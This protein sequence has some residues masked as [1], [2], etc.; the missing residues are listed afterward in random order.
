MA[1]NLETDADFKKRIKMFPRI[2]DHD[3]VV[4]IGDKTLMAHKEILMERM[5]YFR[6]MFTA[7]MQERKQNT[8]RLD[9]SIIDSLAFN[10]IL[11]FVYTFEANLTL[12]ILVPTLR[13]VDFFCFDEMKEYVKQ[14]IKANFDADNMGFLTEI[15]NEFNLQDLEEDRQL[16]ILSDPILTPQELYVFGGQD[17]PDTGEIAAVSKYDLQT[18]QWIDLPSISFLPDRFSYTSVNCHVYIHWWVG[19]ITEPVFRMFDT[20]TQQWTQLSPM[21]HPRICFSMVALDGYL[22]AAGGETT[23]EELNIVERYCI[24]N[25]QWTD[26]SPMISA[27]SELLEL[28]GFLYSI[29]GDFVERYNPRTDHWEYIAPKKTFQLFDCA[30]LDG[31]IYV[32]DDYTFGVYDP[33]ENKWTQLPASDYELMGRRLSVLNRR[34]FLTGGCNY[35][36]SISVTNTEYY[37]FEQRKWIPVKNMNIARTH[38]GVVVVPKGTSPIIPKQ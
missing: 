9:A 30:V 18:D 20:I 16:Y 2:I 22:Y 21:N 27:G 3:I 14:F 7:D 33:Q 17:N 23:T 8:I 31:R 35:E 37:D 13:A 36:S 12:D 28:N 32:V 5:D 34:L 29:G 19:G 1:S 24:A 26:V 10:V 4:K 15:I 38:H 25:D 11:D 6:G